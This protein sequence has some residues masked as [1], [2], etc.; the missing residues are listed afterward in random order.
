MMIYRF[1][2]K[3]DIYTQK[4]SNQHFLFDKTEAFFYLRGILQN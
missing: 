2:E 1:S 4:F 3:I